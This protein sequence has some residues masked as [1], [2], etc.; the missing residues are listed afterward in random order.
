MDT[1]LRDQE[2]LVGDFRE[3]KSRGVTRDPR[4]AQTGDIGKVESSSR[5]RIAAKKTE[6]QLAVAAPV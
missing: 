6:T 3:D 2:A 4:N 1:A 5:F